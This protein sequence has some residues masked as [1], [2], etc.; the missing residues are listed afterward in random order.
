MEM[1]WNLRKGNLCFDIWSRVVDY[2]SNGQEF[3]FLLIFER[4]ICG[5]VL[6]ITFQQRTES[7]V[8]G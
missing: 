4:K 1:E 5:P 7:D 6:E 3:A 2:A 8:K